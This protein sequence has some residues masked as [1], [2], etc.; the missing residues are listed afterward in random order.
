MV[1]MVYI[2]GFKESHFPAASVSCTAAADVSSP[3]RSPHS[4]CRI[5]ESCLWRCGSVSML[6]VQLDA[7]MQEWRCRKH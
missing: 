7:L 6:V 4:C 3:A 1:K 5:V 2:L